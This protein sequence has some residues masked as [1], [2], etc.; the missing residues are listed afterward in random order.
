MI[1]SPTP[2]DK[3]KPLPRQKLERLIKKGQR[4]AAELARVLEASAIPTA[5]EMQARLR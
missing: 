3:F 4:D 1:R 5:A 2:A